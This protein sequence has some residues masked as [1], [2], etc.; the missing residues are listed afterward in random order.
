MPSYTAPTRDTRFIINEMLDLES[1]AE[2]PG[3]EAASADVTDAV[4]NEGGKFCAEVLAPINQSG[5]QE[6]CT[7]HEDGSVT[8]PKG[9]KE[10]FDQFREAG[11][12]TLS[13]PEEFGGQGMPHVLGFAFEEFVSSANQAFGMYPGLTNG[14]VSA[15]L[16]KGSQEQKEKY[17]PKMISNEWTGTMNLTEPHCGT[18]LG[19]IRTK[20]EPQADGSYAITGTK[21]FISAGEHDMADNIIHLV[22]AK[23]PGAPDS[24]KGISLFVVPKF[25]VEEDGSI[26][27]RNGVVCGSIE[28]KMGIHGNATCVLNYDGAKGWLVGEENK[29]LAAMF[30]M[31]N[32][33]RLGV[34][35][36]GLSQAE[37]AYQNAVAYALDRR[38]GRALTGPAEPEQQ[39]DPIFVHPDVRRMLMD[40]K[41]FTE[42][43][44]ALCLWGA[45]QV[46]L[47][48]KAATEEERE[49]ADMLIG[50]LTPVIKGYGTDKGYEVATNMQQVFGGHGYIEEWGMS[51]FVRDA[52]IAQIYEGTNGVQAMDLCGRKLAQKGGAA[53]QAFFKVVGED[54]AEAKGDETLA[55]LA[56][57]MEKA[58]G[59]QQA[60]T[61]W[62]MQNAMQNPNH[63][64]AGAHHYMHIM[65][66]V[67]LGWMWLRMAKVAQAALA[68]GTDDKA[69]YEAKL[70]TA[71]YYMDRYLPDAGALRR[72]LETGSD[73]MMA[74]GEDAF[75]TAA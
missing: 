27:E 41:A 46:D 50:L 75:A 61:M 18:D 48:H 8:A 19:M 60:A 43:M 65:G 37:V 69:F 74:L 57:A 17:L 25:L 6:G 62:F 67:T 71:R 12:G 31:M 56:E 72:K 53:V 52:R 24:T 22:L 73:S 4:I 2:L 54:I 7:R 35:I 36:Q 23:T 59:Q 47:S 66:I 34:G 42:G 68:A 1:Y 26:G 20:A 5:D 33:A 40:A 55:P 64:G 10:A 13:Q 44:R 32:A 16:A 28:H 15:L 58:L 11:W 29:G 45:L 3:F 49:Q 70:T 21:I 14:A 39:A 63:L 9:F 38:Q 51:Q 30:I